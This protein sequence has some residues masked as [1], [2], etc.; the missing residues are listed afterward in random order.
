[1]LENKKLFLLDIDGTICKGNQLVEGSAA[2]LKDI[3]ANGGQFVFITNNATKSIDDYIRFFQVLGINTDYTNFLTASYVTIDYLKK[4]HAGELIYVLGTRSFI[5]ELKK[6]KIHVTSDCEDEGITC[7]VVSYDNQLTYEKLSDTCKLLSTKNVDYLATNPDYVCPIEF[8]FVPDCGSI[9]EML[10]H[11]V[12]RMP[13]FIGKPQPEMVELALQRNHYRKEETLIVGDRL[14]TD[15][16]CGYH[17]GVE[18]VL[19]LSGEATEEEAKAYEHQPDYVMSSVDE[20]HEA[21]IKSIS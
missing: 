4:N 21:W 11:A 20:L 10:A 18:T 16:L 14:Y 13:Y 17:A 15:I 5:R 6:N 7:V 8:G 1:M 9:C 12:K 2:F 3:K 19:V